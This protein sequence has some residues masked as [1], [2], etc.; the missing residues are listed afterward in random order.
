MTGTQRRA[1]AVTPLVLV[2]AVVAVFAIGFFAGQEYLKRQLREAVLG[3]L[4]DW[5]ELLPDWD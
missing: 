4:E 2:L 1:V 3:G 5:G